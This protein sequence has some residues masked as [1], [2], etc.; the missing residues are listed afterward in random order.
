MED[1][2][3]IKIEDKLTELAAIS[4][5]TNKEIANDVGLSSSMLTQYCQGISRP[6]L[7]NLIKLAVI[8]DVSLDYLVF[9]DEHNDETMNVD[10]I[11]RQMNHSL[12]NVQIRTAKHTSLVTKIGHHIAEN[13]DEEI[14]DYLSHND[15]SE[16]SGS[17]PDVETL[18]LEK[19]SQTVK[20]FLRNFNYN[21][22]NEPCETP[23]QFFMTV[24]NNLGSGKK[25]QYLLPKNANDDWKSTVENFKTL[26]EEQASNA[27]VIHSNCEFRITEAPT[28]VGFGLYQLMEGE[29]RK[30]NEMLY[31]YLVD[32]NYIDKFGRF[33]YVAPPSI[34][35]RQDAI[36]DAE[37]LSDAWGMF[38]ELWEEAEPI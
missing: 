32:Q 18:S 16:Y 17:I 26:L 38:D 4:D 27:V 19:N 10:P 1:V 3:E 29:F 2:P 24:A 21:L 12:E 5:Q 25:Y 30:E 36:M 6:S 14:E 34:D 13:L 28:V 8:F 35:G 20:L 7:E 22:T 31:D 23:G 37:Y 33:G 11:V 15:H 9:G